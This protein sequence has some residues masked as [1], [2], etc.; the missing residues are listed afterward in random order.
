M[1]KESQAFT[2]ALASA[3]TDAER[4]RVVMDEWGFRLPMGSA[5]LTVCF[6][7]SF[8]VYDTRV[9]DQLGDFAALVNITR[10]ESLWM[11]YQKFVQ[12]VRGAAPA[13]LS[14]RE[15][16]L[17]LWGRSRHEELAALLRSP[18][19]TAVALREKA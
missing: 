17:W 14:L 19:Y 7:A 15:C 4:F 18:E 13:G 10:L 2:G 12:A 5:V 11:G 6:P 8:S 3:R 1:A 9:C 16:D